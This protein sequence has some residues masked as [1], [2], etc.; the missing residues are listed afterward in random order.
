MTCIYKVSAAQWREP[1]LVEVPVYLE[2][3]HEDAL[4]RECISLDEVDD[5]ISA[6]M[7]FQDGDAEGYERHGWELGQ[8][9]IPIGNL[10]RDLRAARELE[11][12]REGSLVAAY[13]DVRF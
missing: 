5:L 12:A 3:L 2:D 13:Y 11:L 9:E 1:Q 7:W 6:A 10:N 4:D 8:E